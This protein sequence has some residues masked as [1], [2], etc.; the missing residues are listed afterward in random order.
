MSQALAVCKAVAAGDFEARITGIHDQ[1]ELGELMWSNNDMVDRMDAFVRE[2]AASM[3]HVSANKYFRRIVEVGM[4]GSFRR[5]AGTI[6]SATDAISKKM[7][8][9]G[10]AAGDFENMVMSV[11]DTVASAANQLQTTAQSMEAS[12]TSATNEANEVA[13]AAE[14][15]SA[16]VQTV[17][18]AAEEL[19]G[20]IQEIG[21]QIRHSTDSAQSAVNEVRQ[22]NEQVEGLSEA[23]QKIGEV[24]KLISDIA[25]QTNLLALNATIEAA[26]AGD[27]GKGFSVVAS[28]VKNLANQTATATEDIGRQVASIQ[29]ATSG[30]VSAIQGIENTIDS[31]ND[32]V[33]AISAAA[34]EQ[35]AA[36]QE[37]A[38]SVEEAA[39][40]TGEVSSRI[41]SVNEA[42]AETGE[43]AKEVLDAAA[44]LSRQ[45]ENMKVEVE[46]F[47]E[48]IREIV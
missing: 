4:L 41:N 43:A 47:L 44:E 23:A 16:N 6:N 1:G 9:F 40:G 19:S 45:S 33:T 37:I 46:R 17:A 14:L 22:S 8:A 48:H 11:I 39:T 29:N 28:E 18:S 27:A 13:S 2:S 7:E 21:R 15:A 26:R 24:V 30:A 5:S 20:S 34:E 12:A 3:E 10:G 31:V 36:T 35:G 38:R 42:A 25:S 32:A